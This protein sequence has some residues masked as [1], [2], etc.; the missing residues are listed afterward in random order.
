MGSYC[1]LDDMAE[2]KGGGRKLL[3]ASIGLASVKFIGCES[4]VANLMATPFVDT[5]SGPVIGP[6]GNLMIP[7][8]DVDAGSDDASLTDAST[9]AALGDAAP[10]DRDVSRPESDASTSLDA[11]TDGSSE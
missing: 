5:D 2:L 6:V 3:V 4:S 10:P 9:E 1:K 8:A 7:Q 11:T